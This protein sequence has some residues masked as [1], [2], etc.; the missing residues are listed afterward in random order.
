MTG[1]DM[2]VRRKKYGRRTCAKTTHMK[3]D[4]SHEDESREPGAPK[5]YVSTVT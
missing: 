5:D 1:T 2:A 4:G 3:D